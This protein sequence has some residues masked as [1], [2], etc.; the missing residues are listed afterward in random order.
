MTDLTEEDL[1]G[2]V[3]RAVGRWL[4][5]SADISFKCTGYGVEFRSAAM[6]LVHTGSAICDLLKNRKD[7]RAEDVL[8]LI[9]RWNG[10]AL[11]FERETARP[12]FKPNL[13]F[14]VELVAAGGHLVKLLSMLPCA[15]EP[16]PAAPVEH[17]LVAKVRAELWAPGKLPTPESVAAFVEQAVATTLAGAVPTE[18]AAQSI[19]EIQ[20]KHREALRE[21]TQKASKID[22]ALS[23]LSDAELAFLESV[24]VELSRA[25]VKYPDPRR[26]FAALVSEVGEVA[27]AFLRE[28][29]ERV[30]EEA[31]QVAVVAMRIATE[32]DPTLEKR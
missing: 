18:L 9:N 21:A 13:D 1:S 31:V 23:G 4:R 25:K 14:A 22:L 3:D 11:A 6:N 28:T 15:A 26:R 16:A 12:R 30:Q 17:P 19:V 10:R 20:K 27:T 24:V 5:V 32:G 7:L 2:I 29:P 8:H